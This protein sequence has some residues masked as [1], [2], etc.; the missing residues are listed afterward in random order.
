MKKSF[1][2]GTTLGLRIAAAGFAVSL[3]G[4][5]LSFTVSEMGKIW[6]SVIGFAITAIG[7]LVAAFGVIYGW[8]TEGEKAIKGSYKAANDLGEKIFDPPKKI[9]TKGK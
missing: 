3:F 5:I 4:V 7:I 2:D 8:A 1:F 6:L 9:D